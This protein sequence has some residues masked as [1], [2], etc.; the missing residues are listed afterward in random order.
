MNIGTHIRQ[1][2]EKA[3]KT[4]GNL[5]RLIPEVGDQEKTAEEFES[6]FFN[7]SYCM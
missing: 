7:Q 5:E 4:I 2:T 1:T 3:C 6:T